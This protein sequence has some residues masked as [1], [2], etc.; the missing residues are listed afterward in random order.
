M[1]EQELKM[2]Q[3]AQLYDLRLIFSNGE[4]ERYSTQEILELLDKIALGK[5]QQ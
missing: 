2:A 1:A 4:K 3:K 5:D